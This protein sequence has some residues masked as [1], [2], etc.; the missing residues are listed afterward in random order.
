MSRTSHGLAA[1]VAAGLAFIGIA[2]VAL[3]QVS[4][5]AGSPPMAQPD[6][7]QGYGYGPNMMGGGTMPGWGGGYGYGMMGGGM[8]P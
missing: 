8:M 7:P 4:G 6:E 2:P 5:T 1:F 3:A